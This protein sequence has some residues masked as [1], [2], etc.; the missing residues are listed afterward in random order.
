MATGLLDRGRIGAAV[1]ITVIITGETR[2]KL[3]GSKLLRGNLH[4][5]HG[6]SLWNHLKVLVAHATVEQLQP[7]NLPKHSLN[8]CQIPK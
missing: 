8:L 4:L 6:V 1:I 7:L 3:T 2:G 5:K